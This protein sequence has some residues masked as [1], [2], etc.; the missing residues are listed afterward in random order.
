MCV[1]KNNAHWSLVIM[2]VFKFIFI[3]MVVFILILCNDVVNN[4][5][6]NSHEYLQIKTKFLIWLTSSSQIGQPR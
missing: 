1:N 5:T 6:V 3:H 4:F 2:S